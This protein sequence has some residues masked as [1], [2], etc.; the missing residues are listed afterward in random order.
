MKLI[1][2]NQRVEV[3]EGYNE[4]RDCLDQQWTAL[5]EKLNCICIPLPNS[6]VMVRNIL[7]HIKPDGILFTGG[8]LTIEYGGIAPERDEVEKLLLEYGLKENIPILGVCRGMQAIALHFDIPLNTV[9]GHIATKHIIN[10]KI[11]REVNSFHGYK[12]KSVPKDFT[13]YAQSSDGCI[14]AI[15]HTRLPIMGIMWHPERESPFVKDDLDLINDF[16]GLEE[17]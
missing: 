11:N 13:Q 10:G 16:F 8:D 9:Q 7:M 12:I 6:K 17:V 15:Q 3:I 14:E 5:F 1:F 4:R 2:I